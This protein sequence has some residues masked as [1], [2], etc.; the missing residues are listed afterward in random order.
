MSPLLLRYLWFLIC[1]YYYF[2]FFISLSILFFVN[3]TFYTSIF[4]FTEGADWEGA[5]AGWKGARKDTP[6]KDGRDSAWQGVSC[7]SWEEEN[8]D[9]EKQTTGLPCNLCTFVLTVPYLHVCE[10]TPVHSG[11]QR[12]R[13]LRLSKQLLWFMNSAG[14]S[15]K[16]W[17]IYLFFKTSVYKMELVLYLSIYIY[18]LP[19]LLFFLSFLFIYPS[20]ALYWFVLFFTSP[21][22]FFFS[23]ILTF[24]LSRDHTVLLD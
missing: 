23:F 14:H 3:N 6:T 20:S 2:L 13:Q 10:D 15:S 17:T 21:F 9:A 16:Y 11:I 22:L 18:T 1:C 4:F 7:R 24:C 5:P 12:E 19:F 8:E